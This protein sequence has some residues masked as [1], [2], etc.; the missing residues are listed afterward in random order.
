MRSL[1]AALALALAVAW[2]TAASLP[3]VADDYARALADAR[4]RQVPLVVDVWAPWCPSCRF[5]KASVLTDPRLLKLAG[6]FAWLEVDTEQP[7][8]FA[9]V[10]QFPI[11]AW[12]T[13]F[14][15]E[16]ATEKVVLRWMGTATAEELEKLLTGAE[17]TLRREKTDPAGAAME[18]GAAL[19]AARK[20]GEAADAFGAAIEAGG[21]AWTGRPEAADALLQAL[22]LVNDPSRCAG[23]ARR[24]APTLPPGPAVARV[25]ATGLGCASSLEPS[26]ARAEAMA[27]LEPAARVA[28]QVPGVLADDRSGLYEALL[29]ARQASQD[30]AGSRAVARQWLDWIEA[31][32]ARAATPL[33]RSAFDGARLSAAM[34]LGE[35]PRVLPALEA[36]AR[37]LPGQYF[38]LAYLARGYLEAGRPGEAAATARAAAALAEGPRKVSVLLVEARALRAAGDTVGAAAAADQAIRHGEALPEAMRPRGALTAARTLRGELSGGAPARA[39]AVR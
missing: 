25:L 8:N 13:I 16:P 27:A 21:P 15:I 10:E 29:G 1:L 18:R 3:F 20:H 24:L 11:E 17:R 2:P 33:A 36:S 6:R 32:S 37:A 4:A 14:V 7:R 31:E 9:F 23:A 26:P 19:A 28:L 5:M 35:V 38:A 34:I 30:Q 22:S 12:P 39:P